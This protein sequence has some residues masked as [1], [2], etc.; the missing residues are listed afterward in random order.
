MLGPAMFLAP[1]TVPGS[2]LRWFIMH[3]TRRLPRWPQHIVDACP[4]SPDD[5][6]AFR[7]AKSLNVSLGLAFV[8]T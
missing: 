8:V 2:L 3:V 7:P 4:I 6:Y 1:L 5:K